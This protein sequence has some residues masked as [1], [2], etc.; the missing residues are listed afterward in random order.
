MGPPIDPGG[1]FNPPQEQHGQDSMTSA[2]AGGG[3]EAS[4]RPKRRSFAQIIASEKVNRNIVQIHL[5]KIPQPQEN[6]EPINPKSLNFDELGEF[7]FDIVK[8]NY[9]DCLSFNFSSGRYDSREI[10]FKPE[11]DVTPYLTSST[12]P[13]IFKGHEITIRKQRNNVTKVTFKH[14]PLNIP[15]EELLHL[16]SCYGK[17]V[18]DIVHV[19][20]LTNVRNK[21][22]L[23]STRWVEMEL[24]RGVSM[25][26]FYWLEGPLPGDDGCRVT[27]LHNGQIQQCSNCL[28]RADQGCPG[29]GNGKACEGLKTPR[30]YMSVYM[31]SLKVKAGYMTLK[32]QYLEQEQRNFPALGGGPVAGVYDNIV[33]IRK[34]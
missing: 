1:G 29:Q 6:G 32:A 21:G 2:R 17:P 11:V 25:E 20:K 24:E 8:I 18:D 19:E 9:K 27:V 4:M 5:K 15:D 14:V 26:N 30:A 13:L 12:G 10:K 16:C 34:G 7:I 3:G 28:R 22:M 31:K 23:G 33:E